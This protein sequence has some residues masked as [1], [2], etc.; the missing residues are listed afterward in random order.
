MNSAEVLSAGSILI[1]VL[2]AV[3]LLKKEPNEATKQFLFWGMVIPIIFVTL[4]LAVETV[5][6]NE[7]SVTGGPV[8]WHADYDIYVCGQ[9]KLGQTSRAP[10]QFIPHLSEN[11]VAF[12]P[13][14]RVLT[15]QRDAGFIPRAFAH[16]GEEEEQKLDVKDPTGFTNRIGPSDFHEHGDNRIHVE[17]VVEHLEDV[18]LG[19]FFEAIGGELTPTSMRL[20]TNHGEVIVKNGMECPGGQPGTWQVFVYKTRE[21]DI[22][23]QEKLANFVD[24]VLSPYSTIPPGDCIILEFDSETKNRTEK[25]CPFY[26]I[27][28]EKGELKP[29]PSLSPP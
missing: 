21:G 11:P 5:L 20:P 10:Y 3:A 12:S 17:G 29:I 15:L 7:Q 8:H 6:K 18:S 4:F 16:E 28:I 26:Q 23:T 24:Y 2:L 22:V 25:I 19:K 14:R 1:G 9:E 27:A 13:F